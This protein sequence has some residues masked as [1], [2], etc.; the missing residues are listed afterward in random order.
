MDV[1][2]PDTR[3]LNHYINLPLTWKT[4]Y[5]SG[6]DWFRIEGVQSGRLDRNLDQIARVVRYPFDELA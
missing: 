4:K 3:Q 1:N 2:H 6:R 5:G